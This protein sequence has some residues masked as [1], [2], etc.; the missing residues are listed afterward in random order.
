MHDAARA[1]VSFRGASGFVVSPDGWILTNHHVAESFGAAGE[2]TLE[3]RT[4]GAN[5]RLTVRLIMKDRRHDV[6]LYRTDTRG[7]PHLPVRAAPARVGEPVFLLGH[8]Y[9]H[10]LEASFG[11]ILATG[12]EIGGRP[13]VEYSAQTWW[14][15][16]GSPVLDRQGLV[17]AIHWGWDSTGVSNGRLTG[18]PLDLIQRK[19]PRIARA[20]QP[21]PRHLAD[22]IPPQCRRPD[23]WEVQTRL[24]RADAARNRAGRALHQVEVGVESTRPE[25][26]ELVDRVRYH[27]HPTFSNPVVDTHDRAAGFAISLRAWGFFR[28]RAEVRLRGGEQVAVAGM[29]RWR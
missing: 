5:R 8:P 18:V 12:I 21:A 29:V 26:L 1:V 27:L 19:L 25:C 16:S 20:I 11:K 14:G 23:T 22:A 15:S 6:A 17:V 4:G 7:L 10:P 28:T 2:V 13:S 9:S 24:V 3:R